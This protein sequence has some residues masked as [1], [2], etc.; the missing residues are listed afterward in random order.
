[1]ALAAAGAGLTEVAIAAA[2]DAG[3]PFD[4]EAHY[5]CDLAEFA[6]HLAG[7]RQAGAGSEGVGPAWQS[8]LVHFPGGLKTGIVQWLDLLWAA[9]AVYSVLGGT[10]VG[11]VGAKLHREVLG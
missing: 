8:F 4:P 5:G 3:Q 1:V 9:R 2:G 7:A 6:A 10:F 11:E